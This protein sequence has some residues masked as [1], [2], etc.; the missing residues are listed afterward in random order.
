MDLSR[1]HRQIDVVVGDQITEPLGDAAQFESQRNLL[2]CER[3]CSVAAA[4]PGT[5]PARRRM[6]R[7]GR[8]GGAGV[9]AYAEAAG[10][11]SPVPAGLRC[12]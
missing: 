3:W 8:P 4:A 12:R 9:P 5:E 6:E 2:E 7:I 10:S 1:L 11:S